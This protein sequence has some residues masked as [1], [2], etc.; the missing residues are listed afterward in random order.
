M[1][2]KLTAVTEAILPSIAAIEKCCFSSPISE[3][4]LQYMLR[5]ERQYLVAA[6]DNRGS[7][8]GYAGMMTVLD[9]G[10]IENIAVHPDA[11][12]NGIGAALVQHLLDE[13]IRRELL[14][15]TL[16]VR[17]SNAPARALYEKYGFT[18]VGVRKNY[19]EKPTE[20]AIL[21]TKLFR[22]T[23]AECN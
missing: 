13:G 21:M 2:Y 18:I 14:F 22:D 8:L 20:N 23:T 3:E 6:V 12:R 9:E 11:R 1:E 4:M 10:Y 17:E 19:Y 7:I 5:S 15:L 16:E